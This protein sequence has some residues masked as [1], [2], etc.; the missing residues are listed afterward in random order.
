MAGPLDV[1]LDELIQPSGG[2]EERGRAKGGRKG[3]RAPSG[4]TKL[5]MSLD[6]VIWE[7]EEPQGPK[8]KGKGKS[9]GRGQRP[10]WDEPAWRPS[11]GKGAWW[12]GRGNLGSK[13]GT[14]PW[15]E[16]DD[17]RSSEGDGEW[18]DWGGRGWR[19][20]RGA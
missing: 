3:A 20:G 12:G 11:P 17:W 16:H 14:P 15:V 18:E 8:G 4:G 5:D 2:W 13:G 9:K 10:D 19:D 6:D 1:A 7:Q